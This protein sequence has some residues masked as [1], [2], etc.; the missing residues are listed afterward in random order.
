[1]TIYNNIDLSKAL[2]KNSDNMKV[3]VDVEGE[4]TIHTSPISLVRQL[5]NLTGRNQRSMVKIWVAGVSVKYSIMPRE[6]YV[7]VTE[8]NPE[9]GCV[10]EIAKY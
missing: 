4:N 9:R 5:N 6:E 1:M 7:L 8:Y 10:V 2:W 3:E